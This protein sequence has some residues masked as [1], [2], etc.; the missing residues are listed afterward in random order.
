M[1]SFNAPR[2]WIQVMET[3]KA[4]ESYCSGLELLGEQNQSAALRMEHWSSTQV[5]S[6]RP[7]D[8]H[9]QQTVQLY[10]IVTRGGTQSVVRRAG[11]PRVLTE[12]SL[13]DVKLAMD[14]R[15]LVSSDEVWKG[16]VCSHTAKLSTA[17]KITGDWTGKLTLESW[18]TFFPDSRRKQANRNQDG[19]GRAPSQEQK[20]DL[21]GSRRSR[22][23]RDR[24]GRLQG[25]S[26][27]TNNGKSCR[28]AKNNLA[29]SIFIVTGDNDPEV[30]G[31]CVRIIGVLQYLLN[32]IDIWWL[33]ITMHMHIYQ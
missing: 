25:S 30:R 8:A 19:R 3:G 12:E 31:V 28:E 4:T 20:S 32:N 24:Q 26:L 22:R 29:R 7:L 23:V 11:K 18:V 33:H 14:K 5:G 10:A 16:G 21:L 15:E 27:E 2:Q 1:L 6:R 9:T 13:Y 17:Q